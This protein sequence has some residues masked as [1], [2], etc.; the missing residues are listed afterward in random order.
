[1]TRK[2]DKKI[3]VLWFLGTSFFLTLILWEIDG[4]YGFNPSDEARVLGMVQRLYN[5]EVPHKD[6][7]YQTFVGS[8]YLHFFHILVPSLNLQFQRIR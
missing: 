2:I 8:A 5:G 1:M 7:M 3:E 4:K 6:F